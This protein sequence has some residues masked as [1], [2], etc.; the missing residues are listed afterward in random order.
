MYLNRDSLKGDRFNQQEYH[1]LWMTQSW[2]MTVEIDG[3]LKKFPGIN[4]RSFSQIFPD[5]SLGNFTSKAKVNFTIR[6][7][8]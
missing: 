3:S 7:R 6:D 2:P 5:N 1:A 8:W 4:R